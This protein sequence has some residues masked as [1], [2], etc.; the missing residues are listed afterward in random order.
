MKP[1][2]IGMSLAALT[3]G[4]LAVAAQAVPGVA[5]RD[6]A[7]TRADA[8]ARAGQ[9]FA[10]MDVNQD[11]KLDSA[12]RE[13]RRTAAFDRIDANKDGQITR[14]EF[15]AE[16]PRMG[17]RGR[18]DSKGGEARGMGEGHMGGRHGGGR[19]M[20][21]RMLMRM[22]DADRDGTVTLAEMNT[23]AAT[24][25]DM[26]DSNRDGTLTAEERQAARAA[27]RERMRS[28]VPEGSAAT[29]PSAAD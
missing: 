2:V 26:T 1:F 12:D 10:R 8:L 23:A 25:F 27:M 29:A 20:G 13:A 18:G 17:W 28:T 21:G 4:G 16:R 19:H 6:A 9:R 15:S 7:V 14:A 5:G 24:R 22:A 11:G 3:L